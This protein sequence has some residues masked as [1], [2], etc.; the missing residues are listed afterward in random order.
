MFNNCRA[1]F[2]VLK[3]L[4]IPFALGSLLISGCATSQ[5]QQSADSR[6]YDGPGGDL[7][8]SSEL[9]DSEIPT[10]DP[11]EFINRVFFTF[12]QGLDTVLLR[13]VTTVYQTVMPRPVRNGVAN[14]FSNLSDPITAA[15]Q[16][17]QGKPKEAA[18]DLPRFIINSTIGI[19]GIFDPATKMGLEKHHEDFGQTFAVWGVPSGPYLVLPVLGPAYMRD[20]A[21][22]V[23]PW[24]YRLAY[25]DLLQIQ[26]AGLTLTV[27]G[28]V[29]DRSEASDKIDA[30]DRSAID[31]YLFVREAYMQRRKFLINDEDETGEPADDYSIQLPSDDFSVE[32]PPGVASE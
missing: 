25:L 4:L 20:A 12:N 23:A 8:D 29:N 24:F 14:F 2:A 7:P 3:I 19:A 27:S 22:R 11:L 30:V 5:Q 21:A 6:Q 9:I 18:S 26:D 15:N 28:M 13:P 1:G 16:L 17:L 31:R 10:S 32:L